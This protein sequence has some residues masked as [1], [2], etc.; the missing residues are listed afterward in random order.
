MT[1]PIT[2]INTVTRIHFMPVVTN[3][4]FYE[5]PALYRIFRIA[6]EGN[7]GMAL[8]SFDGRSIAEPLELGEVGQESATYATGTV[9]LD[10][11]VS[12]FIVTLSAGT[13]P[14]QIDNRG[15]ITLPDT[16][17]YAIKSRTSTTVIV[18][19]S[20]YEGS[21]FTGQSYTSTYF[22][23]TALASGSYAKDTTWGAGSGDVL[24][25]ADFAWKMKLIRLPKILSD[26]GKA[27]IANPDEVGL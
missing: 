17:V 13:W 10:T 22:A 25:S 5:S 3:Q 21:T 26:S 16:K 2:E 15:Y 1:D 6:K 24:G 7:F 11:A 27:V 14:V 19:A 12:R 20:A 8:P 4:I 9:A 23:D 18:L